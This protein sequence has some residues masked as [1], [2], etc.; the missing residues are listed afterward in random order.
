MI[1][2]LL[3]AG[4]LRHLTTMP[5]LRVVLWTGL[6]LVSVVAMFAMRKHWG[7]IHPLHRCAALSL[8]VH[9]VFVSLAM[10]IR[11]VSAGRWQWVWWRWSADS[12]AAR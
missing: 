4:F 7:R 6:G 8:L 1:S 10:T 12:C 9:L 11:L 3:A 5:P 2:H